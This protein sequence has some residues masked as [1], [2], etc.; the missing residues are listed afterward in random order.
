MLLAT[1]LYL[2]LPHPDH[3]VRPRLNQLLDAG[4]ASRLILVAAPAGF[5]KSSCVSAWLQTLD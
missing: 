3:M 4:L 5:G 2:P 1:K